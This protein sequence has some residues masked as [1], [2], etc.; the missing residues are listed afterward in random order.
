MR[1]S[2]IIKD[3]FFVPED[4]DGAFVEIMHLTLNKVREVE[5]RVNRLSYKTDG[6]GKGET[7]FDYDPYTI[8][9]LMAAECITNWGGFFD[10]MGRPIEFSKANISEVAAF[11]VLVKK[12]DGTDIDM[13]LFSW[14]EKC[15]K[16]LSDTVSKSRIKAEEN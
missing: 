6:N 7:N 15:R 2:K 14:V 4:E 10:D 8:S 11:T 13:D 1:L 3:K 5:S 12:E 9:K 16:E